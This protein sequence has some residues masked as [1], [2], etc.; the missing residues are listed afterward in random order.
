MAAQAKQQESNVVTV[1]RLQPSRMPIA[2]SIASE[3]DV[4]AADWRVL[5]DQIFPMAKTVEAVGMA[6]AYCRR[7]NLDIFKRPVHIVPMWSTALSRMVETVWPGIAEIRTTAARTGQYA[8]IDEVIYG[9]VITKE[10]EGDKEIWEHGR[11]TGRFERLRETISFPEWASVV[12]YRVLHGQRFG[13]HAKVYWEEAY[14]SNGKTGMPNTMWAKRPRGQLDKCVEAAALRKAFPEEIGNELTA[15]EMEGRTIEVA[16][17]DAV[18]VAKL[19]APSPPSP[20]SP[21]SV[22]TIE[23]DAAIVDEQPEAVTGE[24]DFDS[25]SFFEQLEI[26]MAAAKTADAVEAAWSEFDVEAVL[27]TDEINLEVANKIKARA[28]KR[29]SNPTPPSPDQ[30][31]LFPGDLPPETAEAV[32]NL[33]G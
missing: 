13:Y 23:A 27:T 10:F 28:L 5:V 25:A 12:V 18:P 6:L 21:P 22:P 2:G 17:N 9:P 1:A 31:G 14:A 3:F 7:R 16:A 8:G 19:I 29:A 33:R 20:P 26:A 4:S 24:Q 32:R 30:A 11:S 15:E